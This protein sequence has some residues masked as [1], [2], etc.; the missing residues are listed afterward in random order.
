MDVVRERSSKKTLQMSAG[1]RRVGL[2][3]SRVRR[4]VRWHVAVG[5]FPAAAADQ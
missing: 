5:L 1:A 3:P 2:G 4:R